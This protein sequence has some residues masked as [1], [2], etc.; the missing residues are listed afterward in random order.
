MAG[1]QA[2]RKEHLLT[3]NWRKRRNLLESLVLA[4]LFPGYLIAKVIPKNQRLCVFGSSSG[5]QF[6]DNS[7][8]L[9]LHA[10]REARDVTCV[11]I[12]RNP[13]IVKLLRDNGF[14]AEYLYS[15]RG[16]AA[17]VRASKAFV[18]H[19]TDDIHRLLLGGARVIQLWH[20]TP[21]KK[22]GYQTRTEGL[23]RW[24]RFKIGLLKVLYRLFPYLDGTMSFDHFCV[25][26]DQVRDSFREAF[27]ILD[28]SMVT[29]GQPRNDCLSPEFPL[30]PGLFP[31]VALLE[32]LKKDDAKLVAWLPTYRRLAG[33][34]VVNLLFDFGFDENECERML[35][36]L[37]LHL[38][39]KPHPHERDAL[40]SRLQGT[41][42]VHVY[43]P[44]D[45]YPLLRY[46]DVLLTDYS[47]VFFDYLLRDQPVIF[48]P[49]DYGDYQKYSGEFYYDYDLVT[50]GPKCRDW[51]EVLHELEV[52]C[53]K[54]ARGESDDFAT[55]RKTVCRKFNQ[56]GDSFSRRVWQEFCSSGAVGAEHDVARVKSK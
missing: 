40:A 17:S 27:R 19:S 8:Y 26:S 2:E 42:R 18:T 49:F 44:V 54:Q 9:F 51:K 1:N 34:G 7:K 52:V 20:G 35:A 30:Q 39:V 28:S 3:F 25:S 24:M 43:E 50:P 21:L 38:V 33:F 14:R 36:R 6:G 16:V 15:R 31:E 41:D 4:A 13:G 56:F 55:Q 48:T 37:N 29:V 47:S 32:R 11:Y 22:I 5:E 12:S 53:Q 10:A 46:T 45:P 23:P